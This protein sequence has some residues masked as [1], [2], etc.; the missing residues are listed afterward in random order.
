MV[1]GQMKQNK[2][3]LNHSRFTKGERENERERRRKVEG[4]NKENDEWNEKQKYKQS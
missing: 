4:G 3:A 1:C 2:R